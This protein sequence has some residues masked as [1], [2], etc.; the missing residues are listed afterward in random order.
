MD[1]ERRQQKLSRKKV[2]FLS[3]RIHPGESNSS[4]IMK[5]ILDFLLSDDDLAI[6]LRTKFIFKI[7]PMINPD[8]VRY[9][10]YRD[11]LF[12]NDLNRKWV[13]PDEF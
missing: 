10:N 11:S 4:W 1:A 2:I 13:E 3:S 9:G 7:I 6:A 8:G 12:G 5:G